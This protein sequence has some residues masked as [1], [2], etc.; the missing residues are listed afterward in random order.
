MTR[1]QRRPRHISLNGMPLSPPPSLPLSYNLK[2][3][4]S[5]CKYAKPIRISTA[6]RLTQGANEGS[7]EI[8]SMYIGIALHITVNPIPW[9]P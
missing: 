2:F 3:Q 8:L 9:P 5:N 6:L 1:S 4:L 7:I